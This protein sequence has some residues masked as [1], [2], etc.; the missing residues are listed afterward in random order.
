[1]TRF[2]N[3][4]DMLRVRPCHRP[5]LLLHLKSWTKQCQTQRVLRK[6]KKQKKLHS[7]RTQKRFVMM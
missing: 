5:C 1:M 4:R 7:H 2:H 3:R 6:H